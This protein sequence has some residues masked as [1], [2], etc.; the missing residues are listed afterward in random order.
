MGRKPKP[1]PRGGDRRSHRA[2]EARRRIGDE[3]RPQAAACNIR[4]GRRPGRM[5][6]RSDAGRSE[7]PELRCDAHVR[8][9][10]WLEGA[11]GRVNPSYQKVD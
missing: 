2:A 11:G 9:A 1:P 6:S 5:G 4:H 8:Y 7:E 3:D 10:G